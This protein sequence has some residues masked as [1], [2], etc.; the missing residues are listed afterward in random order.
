M[1]LA[2]TQTVSQT[3]GWDRVVDVATVTT[4][5]A[6][7]VVAGLVAFMPY[8]RRPRLSLAEDADKTHSRVEETPVGSMP[9]LRIL[10]GNGKRRRAAQGT[11]VMV[12][13][14][15]PLSEDGEGM[16]TLGHPSLAWP[17]APEADETAAITVF[18]GGYRPLGLG[19]LVRVRLADNGEMM[20]PGVG[21]P[22]GRVV[23]GPPHYETDSGELFAVGWYLWLDLAFGQDLSD[24]RD[25]LPPREGGYLIRLLIGADDGAAR[26]YDVHVGWD[27]NPDL[28]ADEVLASALDHIAVMVR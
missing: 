25:K 21:L 13:G 16:T 12:E 18:A 7:L 14:Y 24:D 27:G 9:Y 15:R 6:G 1:I 8:L 4:A 10:A 26:T 5:T 2:A 20:R 3:T 28:S 19:R 22:D 23:P 17:S 11:R